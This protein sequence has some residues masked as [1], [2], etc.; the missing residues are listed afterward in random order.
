MEDCL[1]FT[2][3]R[4]TH[5]AFADAL[6]KASKEG[7]NIKCLNCTIEPDKLIIKDFI[8]VKL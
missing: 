2:P 4:E 5:S 6:V 1:Y 8:D 3:N 7:V